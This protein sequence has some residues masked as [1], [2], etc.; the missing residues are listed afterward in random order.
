MERPMQ[1]SSEMSAYLQN[2]QDEFSK[3]DTQEIS[4]IEQAV[5][6]LARLWTVLSLKY[7]NS[8]CLEK[9]ARSFAR[10]IEGEGKTQEDLAYE[11]SWLGEKQIR[12]IKLEANK[13]NV[14]IIRQAAWF[15]GL[16][17]KQVALVDLALSLQK[18][19]DDNDDGAT[20]TDNTTDT[21]PVDQDRDQLIQLAC[22]SNLRSRGQIVSKKIVDEA[23]GMLT[24]QQRRDNIETTEQILI[25][26]D[27]LTGKDVRQYLEVQVPDHTH[28]RQIAE[29]LDAK[30]EKSVQQIFNQIDW[31][32]KL[33]LYERMENHLPCVRKMIADAFCA[34]EGNGLLTAQEEKQILLYYLK[35]N[36]QDTAL[37]GNRY[38]LLIDAITERLQE[39]A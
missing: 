21:P 13:R 1:I 27:G 34:L 16:Q 24:P 23:K 7:N 30:K 33:Y 32:A 19:I 6:A 39:A 10:A 8:F 28:V 9:I 2:I 37:A 35:L 31:M 36:K 22:L 18:Q 12:M 25:T 4:Y 3:R 17:H 5:Y 26:P 15:S 11:L 38:Q 20:G 14:E 29:I